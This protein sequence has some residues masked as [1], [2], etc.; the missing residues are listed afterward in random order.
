MPKK[1]VPFPK[2]LSYICATLTEFILKPMK[3]FLYLAAITVVLAL[4]LASAAQPFPDDG[5]PPCDGP[6]GG[7][8]PIDGGISFLIAAGLAFGGK[9]AYDLSKK[10]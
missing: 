3:R 9:K 7:P 1:L 6:F 4:P 8:C 2:D 10:G 5:D